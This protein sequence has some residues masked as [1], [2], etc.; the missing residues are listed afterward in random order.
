MQFFGPRA[1]RKPYDARYTEAHSWFK[2]KPP[3][4]L[5]RQSDGCRLDE[6]GPRPTAVRLPPL[7]GRSSTTF[8]ILFYFILY[9]YFRF[10]P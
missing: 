10:Q 8:F 3:A 1:V 7:V 9:F 6:E 2:D 4:R 5:A